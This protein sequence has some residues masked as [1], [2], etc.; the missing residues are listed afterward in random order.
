MIR[1][2]KT[3]YPRHVPEKTVTESEI[4]HMKIPVIDDSNNKTG[5]QNDH[6]PEPTEPQPVEA[7]ETRAEA[8]ETEEISDPLEAATKEAAENRDRWMRAVA[9]LENYKKRAAHER[10]ILLRY[11]H[12]EVLRDL[13]P[14]KDN[15][16]RAL[17]NCKETDSTK[18]VLEGVAMIAKMLGEVL[19]KHGLT[20]IVALGESFDPHLHEAIAQT[21]SGDQEPNMVLH[22]M[23]KGYLYHD[24][25]LRPSKVV[26]S[27]AV[28]QQD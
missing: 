9:D 10:G 24:R 23:E 3:G 12:E 16:E 20:E 4:D 21:P 27:T 7:S 11:R 15:L 2:R 1:C 25:L 18:A 19:T 6:L 17:D 14:V 5:E 28:E 22:E 13:L 26:V 8:N